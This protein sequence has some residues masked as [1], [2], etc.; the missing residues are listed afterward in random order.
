MWKEQ[1]RTQWLPEHRGNDGNWLQAVLTRK[2]GSYI[3]KSLYDI[4]TNDCTVEVLRKI[5]DPVWDHFHLL[6]ELLFFCEELELLHPFHCYW[7]PTMVRFLTKRAFTYIQVL[8]LLSQS[9]DELKIKIFKDFPGGINYTTLTYKYAQVMVKFQDDISSVINAL[10]WRI[11]SFI[12]GKL[13]VILKK[14]TYKKLFFFFRYLL[15]ELFC[16]F[17]LQVHFWVRH[18]PVANKL[19][20]RSMCSSRLLTK[21]NAFSEILPKIRPYSLKAELYWGIN[22]QRNYTFRRR[23]P[24]DFLW[25]FQQWEQEGSRGGGQEGVVG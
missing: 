20:V 9:Q 12:K 11:F 17:I 5:T 2:S 24:L 19:F 15:V 21:S 14:N 22:I 7:T 23:R 25:V 18:L 16:Q 10:L 6:A 1:S 8:V 3:W 4:S 13:R